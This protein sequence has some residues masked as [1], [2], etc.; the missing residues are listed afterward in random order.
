MA[1]QSQLELQASVRM[2]AMANVDVLRDI[3]NWEKQM[4]SEENRNKIQDNVNH[5]FIFLFSSFIKSNLK[6][7]FLNNFSLN[8]PRRSNKTAR[9]STKRRETNVTELGISKGQSPSIRRPLVPIEM[10]NSVVFCIPIGRC[11]NSS[12]ATLKNV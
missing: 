3:E 2:N 10:G 8:H 11:A 7:V 9:R 4:K 5:Q 1:T 12:W 6:F